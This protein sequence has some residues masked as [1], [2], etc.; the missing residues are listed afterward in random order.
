MVL[1]CRDREFC[2]SARF[3]RDVQPVEGIYGHMGTRP[4]M[5]GT[6]DFTATV[7][8][9]DGPRVLQRVR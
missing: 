9:W 1:V 3:R 4:A 5:R 7:A 8:I 2:R 6:T